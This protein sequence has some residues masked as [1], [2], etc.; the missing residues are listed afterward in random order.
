MGNVSGKPSGSSHCWLSPFFQWDTCF[1]FTGTP[2]HASEQIRI[3]LSVIQ[4]I[5]FRHSPKVP[6]A[7]YFHCRCSPDVQVSG[8][9]QKQLEQNPGS[10]YSSKITADNSISWQLPWATLWNMKELS[11]FPW[12][13]ELGLYI[14]LCCVTECTDPH[15][16]LPPP[17]TRQYLFSGHSS[18]SSFYPLSQLFPFSTFALGYFFLLAFSIPFFLL[19][20][21]SLSFSP[22]IIDSPPPSLPAQW[23]FSLGA[24]FYNSSLLLISCPLPLL[25]FFILFLFSLFPSSCSSEK[26]IQVKKSVSTLI[27]VVCWGYMR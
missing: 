14:V 12:Q 21:I 4:L 19:H 6:G 24:S 27:L 11:W 18:L 26:E 10:A 17:V 3:I 5:C 15:M 13:Q 8:N 23:L 16:V 22:S 9:I 20:F 2:G 25:L 7:E 1:R